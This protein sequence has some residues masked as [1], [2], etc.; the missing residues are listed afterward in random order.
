MLIDSLPSPVQ[1]QTD[2]LFMMDA[3]KVA[4]FYS[5]LLDQQ[6]NQFTILISV[7]CGIVVIIIGATCWWN[8]R[9]AKQQIFEETEEHKKAL[10]RLF[11]VSTSRIEKGVS[12][13]IKKEM[14]S[15]SE[16]MH[17]ELEDYKKAVS[18]DIKHQQAELSRVFALHCQSTDS[19]FASAAWW[20]TAARLY[21]DCGVHHLCHISVDSA[22]ESLRETV[23]KKIPLDEFVDKLDVIIDNVDALP[24]YFALQKKETKNLIKQIK[25]QMKESDSQTP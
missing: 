16:S 17:T 6:S 20:Y 2:T 8:Y 22:L 14:D 11:K 13:S 10:T 23:K 18:N 4:D 15:F 3:G 9:G 12:D 24:D 25:K 1:D 21:N 19:P 7:L 5:S